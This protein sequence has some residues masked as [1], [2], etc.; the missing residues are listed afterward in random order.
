MSALVTPERG[1]FNFN[2]NMPGIVVFKRRW[3]VA[4]DDF[5]IPFGIA[6]V[7]RGLW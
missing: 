5:V 6:F 4:S 1:P 7:L 2:S 3:M